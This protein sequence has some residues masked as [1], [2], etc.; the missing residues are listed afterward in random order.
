MSNNYLQGL[1]INPEEFLG[2]FFEPAENVCIRIFP[3][4]DGTAF[5]AQK[6]ESKAGHLRGILPLLEQHNKSER[7]IFFVVNLGGNDSQSITR[8][9]AH[10]VDIDKG[11]REEQIAV[12]EAFPLEPSL[13]VKTKRGFHVYWLMKQADISLFTHIQK[14]LVKQ[15]NGDP[16]CVD[17]PRVLRIPSFYHHKGEPFL[18]ECVKFNP[19]IR[20]TQ[21][22]LAEHLPDIPY[23]PAE[24][25]K[26]AN[27]VKG[28]KK[29]LV[30]CGK[31]CSFLQYCKNSKNA[32]KLSEPLWYAMI[33]NL[34]VFVGG[35]EAI[36]LF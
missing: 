19:E 10:F 13:V 35:N 12:I 17:L 24:S 36:H 2:A 3:D 26:P 29:G 6:L 31:Q 18:I 27:I 21:S 34:A 9:N 20:Y 16:A 30:L 25:A 15:F 11:S 8:I 33:T 28:N 1:D 5:S 14:Q 22:Q 23:E 32:A 7:G 4:K